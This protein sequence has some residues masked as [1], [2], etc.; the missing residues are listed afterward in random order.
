MEYY[1]SM[2][3]MREFQRRFEREYLTGYTVNHYEKDCLT[4]YVINDSL[5][6]C[7]EFVPLIASESTVYLNAD[8]YRDE[9]EAHPYLSF[10][11]VGE[12]Y[13]YARIV[14]L[15]H[16]DI[17]FRYNNAKF[18][19]DLGKATGLMLLD[20]YI[21]YRQFNSE[22]ITNRGC[23]EACN[24]AFPT[25]HLP[26]RIAA[27]PGNNYNF[28]VIEL[29]SNS[30]EVARAVAYTMQKPGDYIR[31]LCAAWIKDGRIQ[32]NAINDGIVEREIN[33]A[34][35]SWKGKRRQ[36][37]LEQ[38]LKYFSVSHRLKDLADIYG[39]Q[40]DILA[41]ANAGKYDLIERS[42]YLKPV[43]KWVSEE[44]VYKLAK[45]LYKEY[46]VIYQLRPFF[47]RTPIGGQMSYDVYISGLN[48]AIEYQGKQHFES[49]DFFG[50][51]IAFQNVQRRDKLKANLSRAHGVKLVYVN[52]WEDI[53]PAL[54]VERVGIQP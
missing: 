37:R 21:M 47:L 13:Y 5:V 18:T 19:R 27:W 54:I 26:E 15:T 53:T 1:F 29:E 40:R 4:V 22:D 36:E 7:F 34:F 35:A 50:G 23:V 6:I 28:V 48:V 24:A 51:E 31:G 46:A 25:L 52:Y 39:Y 12:P 43:N 2:E 17:G 10:P 16:N 45:K 42:T 20:V 32:S 14:E 49:V 3:T 11:A 33:A 38:H 41:A 8:R 44:L 9:I 30:G